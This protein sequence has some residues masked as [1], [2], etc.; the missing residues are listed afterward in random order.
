MYKQNTKRSSA[1]LRGIAHFVLIVGFLFAGILLVAGVVIGDSLNKIYVR[2]HYFLLWCIVL[3]ILVLFWHFIAYVLISAYA[4][5]VENSDRSDVV[6]ALWAIHD[7]L[8][9]TSDGESQ[10]DPEVIKRAVD[11]VAKKQPKEDD[12]D[13][14][15]IDISKFTD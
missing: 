13:L 6:D 8:N 9:A 12:L 15:K 7:S 2:T 5:I 3:A 11:A 1:Q 14:E 4:T 10:P